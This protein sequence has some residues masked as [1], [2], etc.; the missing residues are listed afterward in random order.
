M[1]ASA[2]LALTLTLASSLI[3]LLPACSGV[4]KE[5]VDFP[6]LISA[7]TS[8]SQSDIKLTTL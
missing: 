8:T 4:Q 6:A 5:L 2:T 7:H 1:D 3:V